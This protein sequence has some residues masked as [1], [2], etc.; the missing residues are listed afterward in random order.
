MY[1]PEMFTILDFALVVLFTN[2]SPMFTALDTSYPNL[3]TFDVI[4][5]TFPIPTIPLFVAL[6]P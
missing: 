5:T 1:F 2:S 4:S 6:S 3:S